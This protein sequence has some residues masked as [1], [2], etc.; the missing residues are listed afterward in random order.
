MEN[1]RRPALFNGSH[2]KFAIDFCVEGDV[3]PRGT[4]LDVPLI[5][6]GLLWVRLLPVFNFRVEVTGAEEF[7][8]IPN[9]KFNPDVF[10]KNFEEE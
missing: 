9:V 7:E 3:K 1:I 5:E 6:L 10:I 4:V 2:L 8:N